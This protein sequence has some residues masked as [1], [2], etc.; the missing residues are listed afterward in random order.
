M[1][2]G[3]SVIGK[4]ILSLEDG[5]RVQDVKDVLL[6]AENDAIVGL[7]VDEG[8]LFSGSHVV[9]IEDVTSFGRDAVV[10]RS[11]QSVISANSAPGIADILDRKQSLLGTKVYTETGDDQ[12]KVADLYFDE[13]SGRVLGLEVS[14]G[15]LSDVASGARYLP[16]DDILR[17]GPDVLYVRPE[18]AS[19]FEQQ[20]GGVTGAFADAG[21]KAR[22]AAGKATT[23]AGAAA[24][25]AKTAAPGATGKARTPARDARTRAG[26]KAGQARAGG[27]VV[28]RRA[29][30]GGGGGTRA[31]IVPA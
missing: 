3:K 15:T 31:R 6:G 11:Q 16:V 20:R 25:D 7:L 1:R 9:P 17:I 30:E 24:A 12:G 4:P 8:G 27:R 5:L 2:K 23:A 28:G 13:S 18:T 29:G 19:E 14:G 10:V 21:D 22:D 26:G